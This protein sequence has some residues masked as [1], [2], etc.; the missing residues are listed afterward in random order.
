V[1]GDLETSVLDEMPPGRKAIAT[2]TWEM[3]R[4]PELYNHVANE[5]RNGKQAY[6]LCPL[7]EESEKLQLS[8]AEKLAADLRKAFS[9]LSIGLIHGSIPSR[10]REQIMREFL[11]KKIQ[12]L[13]ATTVIEVG[14]DVSN[15]SIMVI[16]HAERFGLSQLHQL[17]GRVGRGPE[18]SYCYLLIPPSSK[19][20]EEAKM[21]IDAMV[22]SNDGFKIA[23]TDLQIRGPGEL[24]GT[25]QSGIPT[26]RIGDLLADQKIL[27]VA[28]KEAFACIEKWKNKPEQL[29]DFFQKYWNNRFGLIQIG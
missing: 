15:A 25:R 10:E 23:E 16:E 27:E 24:T 9:D 7:I 19:L 17:R 21:R 11:D 5:V 22:R 13:V 1:Y 18:Q 28:R 26:F 2:K 14:I 8:A 29:R 20:T 3:K 12:M 4:K 6:V